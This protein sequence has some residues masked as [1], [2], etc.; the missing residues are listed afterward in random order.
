MVVEPIDS[1]MHF[2][3]VDP[4]LVSSKDFEN[5]LVTTIVKVA[6]VALAYVELNKRINVVENHITSDTLVEN[7]DAIGSM[8]VTGFNLAKMVDVLVYASYM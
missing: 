7:V 5:D 3:V 4:V 8:N 2:N 6:Y 1:N